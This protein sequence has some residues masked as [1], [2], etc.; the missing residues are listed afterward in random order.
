[1]LSAGRCRERRRQTA[2]LPL[3]AHNFVSFNY[4][5][6]HTRQT[7]RTTM[8]ALKQFWQQNFPSLVV[9]VVMDR[10]VS[11]KCS[12]SPP[13]SQPSISSIQL[14]FSHSCCRW[15]SCPSSH[16]MD[17]PRRPQRRGSFT[18]CADAANARLLSPQGYQTDNGPD[19]PMGRPQ[20]I[21]ATTA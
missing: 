8:A 19:E 5:Q 14:E 3:V 15:D 16:C 21:G 4:L 7:P 13:T 17:T 6:T 10:A 2:G 18:G 9:E 12:K 20:K 11:A 1:M